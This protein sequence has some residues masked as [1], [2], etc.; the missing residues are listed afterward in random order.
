MSKLKKSED[1][2]PFI[3]LY[4]GVTMLIVIGI[5]IGIAIHIIINDN[6]R[7]EIRLKDEQIHNLK[8]QI[9]ELK[10][11]DTIFNE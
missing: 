8:T 11:A 1:A 5:V 3:V 2:L 9:K 6:V 10:Q 4:T 7:D